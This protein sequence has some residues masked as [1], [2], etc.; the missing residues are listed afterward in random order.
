MT[1]FYLNTFGLELLGNLISTQFQESIYISLRTGTVLSGLENRFV[2]LSQLE[3]NL[4][5]FD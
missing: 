2:I 4:S 5:L 1:N 3:V